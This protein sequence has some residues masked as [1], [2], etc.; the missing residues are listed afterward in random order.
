MKEVKQKIKGYIST[1]AEP[2]FK[3][4]KS[5][6]SDIPLKWPKELGAVHPFNFEDCEKVYK[7]VS[8]VH[9]IINKIADNIVGQYTIDSK[10]KNV[11]ALVK[12]FLKE[13]NFTIVAREWVRE[14]LMKGNGFIEIDL[15]NS[16]MK[17]LNAN[18]IYVK[19]NT[20]GQVIEYNQWV[21]DL[22]RFN[23]NSRK[24]ITFNPSQ[25]AHL[26]LIKIADEPYGYGLIMPQE[27]V[28]ENMVLNDQDV[29]KLY[30]RKA[31]A[32][33]H[34]KVG[35]KGEA[36]NPDVIDSFAKDLQFMTNRTEWVTDANTD[37][38]VI[39]FGDIGKNLTSAWDNDFKQLIAGMDCP[40]VLLNSGQLNE[41][42]AKVQLEGWSRRIKS[43]Q[44]LIESVIIEK[45]IK[46]Y[47]LSQGLD[48]EVDFIWNIPGEDEINARIEKL[49]T[50]LN[51]FGTSPN[52]KRIV[53]IEIA[54]LLNIQEIDKYLP[55][56]EE[57]LNEAQDEMNK[58]R[59]QIAND[60]ARDKEKQLK[61]P[62]V[63]NAK[64]EHTHID[65]AESYDFNKMSIKEFISLQEIKGFNYSD[66]L[67][68]ILRR[69]KTDK[70][71]SLSG[72][73]EE[74]YDKGLLNPTEVTKLRTILKEGFRRN[75]TMQNIENN[76]REGISLRD[77]IKE[78]GATIPA[79]SRPEMI[80]RTEVVRL[81]NEGIVDLFKQNNIVQKRWLAALSD[82]TCEECLALNGKVMKINESFDTTLGLVS[83]PPAHQNC[84]CSLISE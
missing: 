62:E 32:P 10:D 55:A 56:P 26:Q 69:V 2:N 70:F 5:E 19:R 53:E 22:N 33:L 30:S 47:L 8:V 14:A 7:S 11:L 29:H 46:P 36:T 18:N 6:V 63:P 59:D 1:K 12:S 57:G 20:K 23:P 49:A 81:A 61:Q 76:I 37:I 50:L 3:E 79:S 80:A 64:N 31:G 82:R 13:S 44:D 42:I 83:G 24:L 68:A 38:G 71:E 21:G 28:V 51:G 66:Y 16:Q 60:I 72:K 74:D 39:D 27:K 77:R 40:E 54:K 45:I 4:F 35:I 9:G 58:E 48:G 43:Y 78:N 67:V 75:Q 41:G 84:R 52:L 65:L 15:K 17:V 34:A 73:I 25:I